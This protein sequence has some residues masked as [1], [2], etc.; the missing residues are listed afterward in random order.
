MP[1]EVLAT[2]LCVLGLAAVDVMLVLGLSGL[3][4][5]TTTTYCR[6]CFRRVTDTRGR[7]R[8][9]CAHCAGRNLSGDTGWT[10]AARPSIR[11]GV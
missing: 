7:R 4:R 10:T 3:T 6:R 9:L 2:A 5:P 11:S 1:L 8:V